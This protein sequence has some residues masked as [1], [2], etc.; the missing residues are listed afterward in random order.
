MKIIKSTLKIPTLNLLIFLKNRRRITNFA[1][2]KKICDDKN[3]TS[4]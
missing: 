4:R 1:P 3:Y 2:S